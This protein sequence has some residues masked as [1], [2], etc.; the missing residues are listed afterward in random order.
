MLR[1][2]AEI[3][4]PETLKQAALLLE[5]ENER[6]HERLKELVAELAK[7]SGKE[8]AKQLELEIMKQQEQLALVSCPGKTY[9]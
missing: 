1:S 9:Q 3:N 2:V 7:L 5:Y 6:L 4:E 8:S